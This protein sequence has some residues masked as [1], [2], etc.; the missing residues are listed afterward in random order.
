MKGYVAIAFAIA[1]FASPVYGQRGFL[2]IEDG[3]ITINNASFAGVLG[4]EVQSRTPTL[5][6]AGYEAA[7]GVVLPNQSHAP[8][9]FGSAGFG[10]ETP[11]H[12]AYGIFGAENV[13]DI[14]GKTATALTYSGSDL[15][16]D[17]FA[18]VDGQVYP[19][20]IAIGVAGSS[21]PVVF[22]M[23]PEPASGLMASLG[24]MSLLGWRRRRQPRVASP[25]FE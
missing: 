4:I 5:G 21:G 14:V 8:F 19:G 13:V 11:T 6:R 1:V 10:A 18:V 22:P 7:P 17:L 25:E 15:R 9:P 3:V 23:I 24:C 2:S 16:A 12:Y 20:A